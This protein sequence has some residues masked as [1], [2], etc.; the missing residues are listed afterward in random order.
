MPFVLDASGTLPWLFKD[1]ATDA[2]RSLLQRA[3]RYEQILVPAH[4][5]IEVLNVL[6]VAHRKGR[7][8]IPDLDSFLAE[9]SGF[10]LDSEPAPRIR[11]SHSIRL[12]C[13]RHRLTAYDAAY[14]ELALRR[15]VPLATFDAKLITAAQAEGVPLLL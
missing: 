3:R 12:L 4:W 9:L 11:D 8:A 13:S 5:T 6:L 7:I 2:T 14:L 15:A 10:A 1:E